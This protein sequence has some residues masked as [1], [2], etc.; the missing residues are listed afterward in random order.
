MQVFQV[1]VDGIQVT[2]TI[3]SCLLREYFQKAMNYSPNIVVYELEI[4]TED[5]REANNAQHAS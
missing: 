1:Q 3:I 2:S 5:D 4:V